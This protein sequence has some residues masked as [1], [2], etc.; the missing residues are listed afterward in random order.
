MSVAAAAVAVCSAAAVAVSSARRPRP[1]PSSVVRRA[2]VRVLRACCGGG[3]VFH[4][5]ARATAA[6]RLTI[7][8]KNKLI[9]A[10]KVLGQAKNLTKVNPQ[11]GESWS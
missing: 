3:V 8:A 5:R 1:P 11:K 4:P 7:D 9:V 10:N 2:Q 6:K